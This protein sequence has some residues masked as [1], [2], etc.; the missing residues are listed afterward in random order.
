MFILVIQFTADSF[1]K[2]SSSRTKLIEFKSYLLIIEILANRFLS[3]REKLHQCKALENTERRGEGHFI[4]VFVF[5]TSS[6]IPIFSGY[7][8]VFKIC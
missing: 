6:H 2:Y 5:P 1:L 4:G 8:F 7:G 3:L